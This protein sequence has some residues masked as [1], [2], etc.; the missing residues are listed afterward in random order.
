MSKL[1]TESGF[2][3]H[4]DSPEPVVARLDEVVRSLRSELPE[5]LTERGAEIG[6]RFGPVAMR[7]SGRLGHDRID[8]AEAKQIGRR[9]AHELR[10]FGRL[11]RIA[12]ED[13]RAS[14]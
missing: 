14:L 8:H 2:L 7:A 5:M 13:G 11:G 4:P 6:R 9:D 12:P 1:A 10:R 3:E